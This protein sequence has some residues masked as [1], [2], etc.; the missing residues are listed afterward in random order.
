MTGEASKTHFLK[1]V[2][3]SIVPLLL[4]ARGALK[5]TM[6][7]L[8][9]V[10]MLSWNVAFI[11]GSSKQGNACLVY[12]GCTAEYPSGLLGTCYFTAVWASS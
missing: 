8:G 6:G 10:S 4:S 3:G 5:S 9:S 11:A 12:T 7:T 1:P 2:L